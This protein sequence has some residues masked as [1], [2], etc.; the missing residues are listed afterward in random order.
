M[1][2][3]I[4]LVILSVATLGVPLL[5]YNSTILTTIGLAIVS[6]LLFITIPN[7]TSAILFVLAFILGTA[8]EAT[9]VHFNILS[10]SHP[11]FYGIPL[12]LSFTWG[13][14]ALI[15]IRLKD[16]IDLKN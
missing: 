5:F 10:F 9:A 3:I 15:V 7:Q 13:N 2:S 8:A 1:K 11:D 14:T 4:A 12:W 16:Y 6:A